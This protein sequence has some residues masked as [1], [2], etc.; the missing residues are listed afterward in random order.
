MGPAAQANPTVTEM[1]Y[2]PF[3]PPEKGHKILQIVRDNVHG[4]RKKNITIAI[5]SKVLHFCHRERQ[6]FK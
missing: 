1:F 6:R 4:K 2:S 5:K 3:S